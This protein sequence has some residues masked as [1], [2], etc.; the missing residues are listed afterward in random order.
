MGSYFDAFWLGQHWIDLSQI[1]LRRP[2]WPEKCL[3]TD[4]WLWIKPA[5]RIRRV[6]TGPGT[7]AIQDHW[8]EP[9]AYTLQCL[10]GWN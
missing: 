9:K 2:W 8:V 10:K 6:F 4:K 5:I 3:I 1:Q 7:P